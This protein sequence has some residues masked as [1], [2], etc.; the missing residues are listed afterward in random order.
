M[1][2]LWILGIL[3][4]ALVLIMPIGQTQVFANTANTQSAVNVASLT[5]AEVPQINQTT[6]ATQ[7][8][9]DVAKKTDAQQADEKFAQTQTPATPARAYAAE[10]AEITIQMTQANPAV[11]EAEQANTAEAWYHRTANEVDRGEAPTINEAGIFTAS[12]NDAIETANQNNLDQGNGSVIKTLI[13]GAD[14]TPKANENTTLAD[15]P[16]AL[17]A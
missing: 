4:V 5:F 14:I 16:T 6:Q 13:V 9:A 17:R 3:V 1:K 7:V 8:L 15:V 2:K 11:D 12:F 10:Q